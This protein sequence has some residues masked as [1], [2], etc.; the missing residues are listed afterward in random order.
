MKTK[1][2]TIAA[3]AAL[4]ICALP[5]LS[6][7]V[8]EAIEYQHDGVALKGVM[9]YDSEV[10]G[11]RPGVLIV[12]EWW[13]R[14]EYAER[15]ARMLAEEGFV[16]FALD[17]YGDGVLVDSPA[18]ARALATPFYADRPLMR[19]RAAAGLDVLLGSERVDPDRVAAIGYCFGGTVVLEMAR[20]GA[21]LAAVVCYHGG[22]TGPHPMRE[23]AF[24]GTVLVCNGAADPMVT[25][26]DKKAFIEEMHKAGADF[27]FIDYAVALH[28]FTNP[29]AD[30]SGIDGVGYDR[31][32]DERSWTHTLDLFREVFA[33]SDTPQS[34][35][36]AED[37]DRN[38]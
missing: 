30:E 9:V 25:A 8:S 32:A 26:D 17:M 4:S 37:G 38:D 2:R 11:P 5:A 28:S 16:A 20:A 6:E 18:E 14:D 27:V 10:E 31:K 33:K 13:G 1:H 21:P 29:E 7:I 35:I 24:A 15:R 12:H 23:G 34:E 22:L 19:D 3:I 36:E